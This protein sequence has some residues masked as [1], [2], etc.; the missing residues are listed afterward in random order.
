MLW[1]SPLP[2][3]SLTSSEIVSIETQPDEQLLSCMDSTTPALTR[4]IFQ[5]HL[6]ISC[7]AGKLGSAAF[8]CSPEKGETDGNTL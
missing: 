1:S 4:L 5:P 7:Q 2:L 8:P 6:K 3:S